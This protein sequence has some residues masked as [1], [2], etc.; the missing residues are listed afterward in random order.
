M[1]SP[2]SRLDAGTLLL[3]ML[4]MMVA[5][6]AS[7]L[8]PEQ[9]LRQYGLDGWTSLDG[10]P[11]NSIQAIHQTRDGY[12]W[13]GTQEGL[14]RFDGVRFTVFDGGNTPAFVHDDVQDLA[15]TAD[16]SLW[17]ATYGGGLLR[18]HEGRFTSVAGAAGADGADGLPATASVMALAVGPTGTLWIG[19]LDAGLFRWRDGR[20][21]RVPVPADHAEAGILAVAEDLHG[22]LWLGTHQGLARCWEGRWGAVPLPPTA[23]HHSIWALHLDADGTLW[24]AAGSLLL[25]WQGEGFRAFPAPVD[26]PWDYVCAILRDAAG[27]LWLG[28]YNGG[29]IRRRNDRFE[30]LDQADGLGGDSV[31]ALCQDREGSLWVGTFHGGLNRLHDT[32]FRAIDTAAG[33]PGDHVRAALRARDGALWVGLDSEGLVRRGADGGQRQWRLADGLP[34]ATVHALAEGPDGSMWAGTDRGLVHLT[35]GGLAVLDTRHGLSHDAVRG[36]HVDREGRVWVGTKGGGACVVDGDRVEA[37]GPEAGLP[38]TIVRWIT[39]DAAGRIWLGTESGVVRRDGEGR[40]EPVAPGQGLETCYVVSIYPDDDGVVW[41]G[42]YG[43]GL[44]RVEDD[45]VDI[46]DTSDGLFEDAIYAVVED[47]RGRL[48]LPCNRGI[49]GLGKDQIA[50]YLAGETRRLEPLVLGPQHGMPGTECNGGSQPSSWRDPDGQI[51]FATNGGLAVFDPADVGLCDRAPEVVIEEVIADH[52]LV[53]G[54]DLQA[55]PPGRRDLE[56]RYTGLHFHDPR[57]I[58]FRYRLEGYDADWVDAGPRR[59]A[60]YTNLPPGHYTF[61]VRAANSDGLWSE[62]PTALRFHL[63]PAF[64]ETGAFR[65]LVLV[66]V[67]LGVLGVWRWREGEAARQRQALQVQVAEKTRE[68]A[69]AKEAA[70]AAKEAADA[71][72]AAKSAFLANMSH[73]IRTPMNA[74]IG[75]TDLLRDTPLEPGQRESLEIV[76]SSARGLL[77][78]LNDILDFSKIEA[79]KLELERTP[80]EIR[81]VLDDALRTLVLRADEKGLDLCGRV[82]PDVPVMLGG[83]AMRL[84]QV[85]MNLLGNAIKFTEEGEVSVEVAAAARGDH[86]LELSVAVR[87]TG[88]GMTGEQQERIFAP[89]TQADTSVT[90]R[91]G[92]TGLGLAISRR[93]VDLFG[94]RLAVDS[95]PGLGTEFRF[96]AV[97]ERVLA[98]DGQAEPGPEDRLAGRRVMVIDGNRRHGERLAEI[99]RRWDMEPDLCTTTGGAQLRLEQGRRS[100]RPHDLV[101]CEYDPPGRCPGH[102]EGV[103]EGAAP[104]ICV[105]ARFGQLSAAREAAAAGQPVILKPVKQAE[106]L[107]QLRGLLGAGSP[108]TRA[109]ATPVAAPGDDGPVGAPRRLLVAEDNPVNQV[110]IQR[111][112]ARDGHDVSLVA[113]GAAAV[114]ALTAADAAFDLV[115][116]DLQMPELD[117]LEATR[118]LREHEDRTGCPRTPVIMLT[119]C[120]MVGDRERCLAAG[121]DDHVTKPVDIAE[122]RRSMD[123]L[124]GADRRRDQRTSDSL[125]V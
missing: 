27:S 122:L 74:V 86:D 72:N 111:L 52:R 21:E 51:A 61:R 28:T 9:G 95:T 103:D 70:D 65:S 71:A 85:L 99:C 25:A 90:R 2:R 47:T 57:G 94:G 38:S 88:I 77:S 76:R 48:W 59:R 115:L 5:S 119:A 17:I 34:G 79:G 43:N 18:R 69:A 104:A 117:G 87:D 32:P 24:T 97:L 36:L 89:F 56:I 23:G 1:P 112:L 14:V 81:E 118:S 110:V 44:V 16:G 33:L 82:A 37:F 26:R 42:T 101:L 105:H 62:Q 92:G 6:P 84:R 100:G 39:E 50:A 107:S 41:L 113:D 3:I 116:M 60:Y 46:L 96:T 53:A 40:F 22:T 123:R 109:C 98:A 91:H 7:A 114:A 102:L 15:E 63:E 58:R 49:F 10:L 31:S 29:L 66:A 45:R 73:E 80:F 11:Q 78:L 13:F 35:A 4:A 30:V 68:L 8:D 64:H 125:P 124:V 67:M 54:S 20:L 108:D 75:M 19:T 120:A 12:L 55:I 83:D 121:A 93:L 106:L